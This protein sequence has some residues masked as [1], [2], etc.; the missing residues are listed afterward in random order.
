MGGDIR[1]RSRV[2]A[3]T[4]FEFDVKLSLANE[5]AV[6]REHRRVIGLTPGQAPC[7]ILVVDDTLEN[8]L[9]LNELLSAVGF[10]VR[11]AANGREAVEVWD[12]WRPHLVWMDMRMPVMDGREATRAIRSL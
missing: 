10:E 9:L 6:A 8:R 4:I 3:G 1:V 5:V 11:E 7:R 12:E 2:G